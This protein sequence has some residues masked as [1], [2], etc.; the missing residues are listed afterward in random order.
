LTL[1]AARLA[2]GGDL[3]IATAADRIATAPNMQW[4][5]TAAKRLD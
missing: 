2:G 5:S 1:V 4:E 3:E